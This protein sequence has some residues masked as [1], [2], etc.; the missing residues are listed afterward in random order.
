MLSSSLEDFLIIIYKMANDGEELKSSEI[1]KALNMPLK[2]TIQALQ[3]MH[4]Q[5]YVVYLPYQPLTITDKGKEMAEYLV[6]RN[7]LLEEFLNVLQITENED[8]KLAMRQY[9]SYESLEAI[10]K[11]VLFVR[12]YPEITNRYKLFM[13]RTAKPKILKSMPETEQ[14]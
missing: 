3:R 2:K 9:L 1:S 6:S 11:F 14:I 10:E 7:D 4:Y 12:Q 5:K 13:K 8:E